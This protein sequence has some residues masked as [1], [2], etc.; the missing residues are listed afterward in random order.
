MKKIYTLIATVAVVF[1][2]S[3]QRSNVNIPNTAGTPTI[4]VNT[5]R[6]VGDTVYYFDG[7]AFYGTGI[8]ATSTPPFNFANDDVDGLTADPGMTPWIPVS[9]WKFF[10]EE[11]AL[12]GDTNFFIGATSWFSP[13]AQADDW[14]A[15]GPIS[16][17]AAGA[18]LTWK[19]NIPDPNYSDGYKIKVST[20]GLSNYTDFTD[21]AIFT[22]ADNDPS[23]QTDTA[24]FPYRVFYS[25]GTSLMAYAGQDIYIAV[26]HDANDMF[27]LYMDDFLIIEGPASVNEFVN[28]AR[29]FQN[30]PNPAGSATMINYELENSAQVALNVYDVTGKMVSSLNLGNQNAGTHNLNYSVENLSAGVYYYSLTVD[31]GTSSAMKMVVIK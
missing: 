4:G 6:A 20:T 12:P 11:L 28:G 25:R 1:S 15:V 2:A 19:H 8:S 7:N 13:L 30:S 16:I 27:I 29:L 23:A 3:A 14:F 31:N 18:A 17:P 21:P 9:D 26:H 22:L 24:G 5:T 10:Y